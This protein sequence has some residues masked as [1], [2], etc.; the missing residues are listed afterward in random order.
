[1]KGAC[2]PGLRS[3]ERGLLDHK[4]LD[5]DVHRVLECVDENCVFLVLIWFLLR[6]EPEI[7][8]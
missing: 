3:V 4:V 7:R 8:K 2:S 1:M 5:L 6:L